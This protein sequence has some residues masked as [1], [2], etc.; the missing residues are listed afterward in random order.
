VI[1]QKNFIFI[2]NNQYT[3]QLNEPIVSNVVGDRI[4]R[5]YQLIEKH[6]YGEALELLK[7]TE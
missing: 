1:Q 7:D 6:E 5:C 2:D 3:Y 4:K